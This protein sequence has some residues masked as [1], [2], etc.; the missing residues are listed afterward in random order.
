MYRK[1]DFK[2]NLALYFIVIGL[3]Y[4][5]ENVVL[6]YG[7]AYAYYPKVF[8][9]QWFDSIFGATVSQ[10]AFIPSVM[11]VVGA[12]QLT[13]KWV[14]LI[15][16]AIAFI[17]ELFLS[18]GIYEHFWWETVYTIVIL[19]IATFV[20]KWLRRSLN[21][22]PAWIRYVTIFMTITALI[23]SASFYLSTI[24]EIHWFSIGFFTSIYQDH[25]LADA[26]FRVLYTFPL[27]YIVLYSYNKFTLVCLFFAD[28]LIKL[29]LIQSGILSIINFGALIAFSALLLINI[30]IV[31]RVEEYLF[32]HLS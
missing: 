5:L 24:F 19:F 13:T 28:I 6:I 21:N 26:I 8:S 31:K 18:I 4:L 15:L 9:V 1:K 16:V 10:A 27:T 11:M 3:A 23:Q 25:L 12:F 20:I 2:K 29:L 30:W 32:P 7:N 17:E 14:L 22:P